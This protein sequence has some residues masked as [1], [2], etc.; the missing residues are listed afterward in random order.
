LTTEAGV[1]LLEPRPLVIL[2]SSRRS[3]VHRRAAMDA[4]LIKHY[5]AQGELARV[6]EADRV[7][8]IASGKGGGQ[9]PPIPVVTQRTMRNVKSGHRTVVTFESVVF[10]VGIEEG[11]FTERALSNPPAKWIR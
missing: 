1:F 2:K 8:P 9:E 6:F 3:R 4:V 10:D 7:E 5:D 11:V